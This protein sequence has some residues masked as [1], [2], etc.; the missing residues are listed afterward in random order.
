VPLMIVDLGVPLLL[1]TVAARRRRMLSLGL[2][3]G[4]LLLVAGWSGYAAARSLPAPGLPTRVLPTADPPIGG[5]V[6]SAR[7]SSPTPVGQDAW[8]GALVLGSLLA[9]AWAAGSGTRSRRAY[10]DELRAHALDLENQRDQQAALAVAAERA[11][12]SRELHDVVAHG[13]SVMIAQAQGGAA[14][15]HNRP[16]DTAT[17]LNAVVTTG[18]DALAEMRRMLAR[19]DGVEDG[20]HPQPGLD[21]LPALI[22][23]VREA[24]TPVSLRVEGTRPPLPATVDRSAYRVV[25]EALT[26]T[27]K[28]A[29]AGASATVVLAYRNAEVTLEIAD[30]GRAT[31]TDDG[32]GR[33]LRGMRERVRL[34]SGRLAAGPGPAGGFVVRV[35]LPIE[36]PA[37]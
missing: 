4:T 17:A 2:L 23:Q 19:I 24:G 10:L 28:H 37:P 25:Q 36:E 30:N 11:W 16:A 35:T 31:T 29:G 26:N 12:I 34:L 15:L 8:S 27:M 21:R 32:I 13:L 33:G 9:A 1:Y 18:R 14:A 3:A 7:P 22:A 5:P 6:S 20:W